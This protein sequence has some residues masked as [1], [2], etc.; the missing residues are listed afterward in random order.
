MDLFKFTPRRDELPEVWLQRF[1]SMLDGANHVAG[2]G[3]NVTF[4]SWMSLSLLQFSPRKWAEPLKDLEHRL[5]RIREEY[6]ILQT[7]ML[8][9]A[10]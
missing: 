8:R 5:P 2:W 3:L 6:F 4:Q 7:S 9:S 1:G 10:H